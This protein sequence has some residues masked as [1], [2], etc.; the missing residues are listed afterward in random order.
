[1]KSTKEQIELLNT[2]KE[3]CRYGCKISYMKSDFFEIGLE[4]CFPNS[5]VPINYDLPPYNPPYNH[6]Y[7]NYDYKFDPLIRNTSYTSYKPS[8]KIISILP[9]NSLDASVKIILQIHPKDREFVLSLHNI[10][11]LMSVFNIYLSKTSIKYE[12]KTY[13]Y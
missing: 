7:L 3:I 13:I 8:C 11:S 2:I 4:K 5:L 12:E 1:M 6:P 9:M 10:H